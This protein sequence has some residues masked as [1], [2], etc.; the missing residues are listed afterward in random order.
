MFARRHRNIVLTGRAAAATTATEAKFFS[1]FFSFFG[2][3]RDG[4]LSVNKNTQRPYGGN[5]GETKKLD[6]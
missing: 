1:P 4:G 5:V 2:D 6:V 3:G